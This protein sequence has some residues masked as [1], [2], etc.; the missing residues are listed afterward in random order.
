MMAIGS[1]MVLISVMLL[2][3]ALT[4]VGWHPTRQRG[5]WGEQQLASRLNSLLRAVQA[6]PLLV[7]LA[8]VAFVAATASGI[9]RLQVETDFTRNFRENSPIVQAYN[10]VE[11]D[12]GGAGVWDVIVPAPENLNWNYVVRILKLEQ[13]LRKEVTTPDDEGQPQAAL[14]VLSMADAIIA[15]SPALLR[16][17]SRLRRTIILSGCVASMTTHMPV[18]VESL[19][20][21]DTGT[22]DPLPSSDVEDSSAASSEAD[23]VDADADADSTGTAT[24]EVDDEQASE[25]AEQWY[26]RV[27][28]RAVERQPAERKQQLIQQVTQISREEFPEAE[29]TGFF[30]LLTNLIGSIIRDQWLAF[31]VAMGGIFVT[32]LLAFLRPHYALIA[33]VPNALPILMV[34]GL[35]GWLG[36]KINMGAA[37]IAAVSMGLSVDS[38]IH[39]LSSF[40]RARKSGKSVAASLSEVQQMVGRAMV[41]STLALIIGFSVLATSQFIPTIYFGSLVSLTML[42][43]LMGNL[44]VLPLLLRLVTW[45]RAT[46]SP[47]SDSPIESSGGDP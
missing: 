25:E 24:S 37:M 46:R 34:T 19:H 27:M 40:L 31:G 33:L 42:G 43:G 41:F 26:F 22:T 32:M 29:V 7:G 5:Q 4:L 10:T 1:M 20:G 38:S 30:V 47:P 3:P 13:R 14:K 11:T 28:L 23:P 17:R 2:V 36:L 12:L 9:S 35:M 16:T 18:V 8:T 44:I 15:G 21:E 39:Y 6:R 45:D